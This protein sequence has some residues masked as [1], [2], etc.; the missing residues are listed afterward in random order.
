MSRDHTCVISLTIVGEWKESRVMGSNNALFLWRYCHNQRYFGPAGCRFV[1][2]CPTNLILDNNACCV[3]Q[4]C[5]CCCCFC[6]RR[7]SEETGRRQTMAFSADDDDDQKGFVS[8]FVE[9]SG[10]GSNEK[11]SLD[12]ISKN[13]SIENRLLIVIG[14]KTLALKGSSVRKSSFSRSLSCS[15][16]NRPL[17]AL[18]KRTP[19]EKMNAPSLSFFRVFKSLVVWVIWIVYN[20]ILSVRVVFQ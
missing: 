5:C 14:R 16:H 3:G 18:Q 12:F 19:E 20:C 8:A 7:R 9:P 10:G 2:S 17:Q 4:Y 1:S 6:G 15:W 13:S 11:R